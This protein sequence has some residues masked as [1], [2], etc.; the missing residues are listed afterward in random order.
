MN[1]FF[2]EE[3]QIEDNNI[4]IVGND[5]KHI[6]NVLRLKAGEKI[7]VVCQGKVYI[8]QILDIKSNVVYVKIID[9]MVG[10]NEPP[11]DIVLF[12]SIAKGDKMDLIVQKS[13][14]VGVKEIFPV[15][16]NRTVVKIRDEK[17]EKKKVD[18]WK[19]ICLEAAKQSKRDLVPVVNP[20]LSFEEMLNLLGQE[21]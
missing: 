7:E 6:K 16:T 10:K 20:I 21:E 2:V 17:K 5:V 15:I 18:R 8:C 4:K 9:L 19:T 13:T 14:E 12:Q 11:I 3:Q 1:R